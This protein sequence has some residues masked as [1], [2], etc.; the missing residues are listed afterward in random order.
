MK[1]YVHDIV[2]GNLKTL[3]PPKMKPAKN[4]ENFQ[5]SSLCFIGDSILIEMSQGITGRTQTV[6]FPPS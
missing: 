6:T 5:I 3:E 1:N 4:I 2:Y